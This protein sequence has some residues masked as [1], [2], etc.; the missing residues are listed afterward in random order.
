MP[1][2]A[3]ETFPAF[4]ANYIAYVDTETVKEAVDRYT[5]D[6]IKFWRN[7]P[8][9]KEEYSYA[10]GK[11]T[12]KEMVQHV[13][14]TERIFAYRAVCI[15]RKDTTSLPGFDENFYATNSKANARSWDD[16]LAELEATRISTNFLLQSF[17]DEQLQ[18]Q[19]FSNNNSIT[20][21]A[22]GFIIFGHILHH[23]RVVQQRYL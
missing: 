16:L 18:E 7:I 3:P 15:A 1:K 6:I 5:N 23:I 2:P 14:D 17:D 12:I 21:N 20:V 10:E 13:I 4:Y 22:I 11:W 8:L 9:E 19:G